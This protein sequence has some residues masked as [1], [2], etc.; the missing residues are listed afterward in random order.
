MT[1]LYDIIEESAVTLC[2]KK[3]HFVTFFLNNNYL[4]KK[5]VTK[6]RVTFLLISISQRQYC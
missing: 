6:Y 2:N 5:S 3:R 4:C 1:Y